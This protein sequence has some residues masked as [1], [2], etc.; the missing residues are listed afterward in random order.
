MQLGRVALGRSD[1]HGLPGLANHQCLSGAHGLC[2]KQGQLLRQDVSAR[3]SIFK[4]GQPG[5]EL[6]AAVRFIGNAGE[7]IGQVDQD[8]V[9]V[10]PASAIQVSA[11]PAAIRHIADLDPAAA[12]VLQKCEGGRDRNRGGLGTSVL[13]LVDG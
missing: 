12:L 3:H 9:L 10:H 5:A 8:A 6:F 2:L 1:A 7:H 11:S 13:G 4:S